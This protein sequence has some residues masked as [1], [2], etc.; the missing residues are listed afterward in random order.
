MEYYEYGYNLKPFIKL[1]PLFTIY[2][3]VSNS[4]ILQQFG[5]KAI[6]RFNLYKL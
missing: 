2:I 6:S 3:E 5:Y 1:N 4:S